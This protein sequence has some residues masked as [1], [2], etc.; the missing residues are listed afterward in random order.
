LII[1]VIKNALKVLS[2]PETEFINIRKKKFESVL[3]DYLV[4]LI[5]AAIVSGIVSFLFFIGKAAYLDFFKTVDIQYM[6]MLNYSLG[7]ST[8]LIFFYLFAGTFL[9]FILSIIIRLFAPKV[10]YT[11]VLSII[12]LSLSPLLLFSWIPVF[13]AAL[14]IWCLFLLVVGLRTEK[15]SKMIKKDSIEQRD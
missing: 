9:I 4:L 14:G 5:T 7:R 8:S 15:S 3:G 10:K 11:K 6:R 1:R 13:A 12:F 2:N